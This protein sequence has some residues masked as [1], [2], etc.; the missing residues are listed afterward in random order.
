[1]N[2]L[3][4]GYYGFGNT[5]DEAVLSAIIQGIRERDPKARITVLYRC[6]WF[7][8]FWKMLRADIFVSGGG[9]LFQNST[10]NRSFLYYIGLVWLA[11]LLRKK[12][13]IFAQGFGPLKGFIWRWIARRVLN[14]VNLITLR[15]SES[16]AELKNIGVTR[17]PIYLTADPASILYIPLAHAGRKA[18]SLEGVRLE[19][20]PLLGVCIRRPVQKEDGSIYQDLAE[21][22]DWLVRTQGYQ[23]VFVP[24]QSPEDLQP[25]LEVIRHMR[26]SSKVVY[27]IVPPEEMLS[28]IT[29]FD[30]LI[31][32]RLHA[33]IFAAAASVPML[34]LSYD[35]KVES[36]MRRIGQPCVKIGEGFKFS[37]LKDKLTRIVNNKETIKQSLW[38]EGKTL[39]E[40]AQLNFSLLFD[41]YEH[42]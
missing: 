28:I 36:F 1:M 20:S 37:V 26:E 16:C 29:Q 2:I 21:T 7:K 24:F 10:S 27:K 32:M 6:A 22:I 5:G 4:S 17:P 8:I 30:L 9:T 13:M 42:G 41:L 25:S 39:F 19:G 31:S 33:L 11:K 18:L 23:P 14:R 35:P 12:T 34:G 38:V 40:Q 3:L 15:D